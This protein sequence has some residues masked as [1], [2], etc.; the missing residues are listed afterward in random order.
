MGRGKEKGSME[1]SGSGGDWE[2]RKMKM[3]DWMRGC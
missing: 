3:K 2:V 1:K